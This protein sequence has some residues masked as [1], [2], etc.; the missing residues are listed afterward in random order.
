[1]NHRKF[2]RKENSSQFDGKNIH[3]EEESFREN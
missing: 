2:Y 1:M 3:P